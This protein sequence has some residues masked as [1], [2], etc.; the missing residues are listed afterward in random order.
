MHLKHKEI[1]SP[2]PNYNHFL[3]IFR[4]S[5]LYEDPFLQ[6]T[7]VLSL[8]LLLEL[9]TQGELFPTNFDD[10]QLEIKTS[11]QDR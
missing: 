7:L 2:S 9:L 5:L 3:K 6:L 11:H 10:Q 1:S 8:Q 4:T